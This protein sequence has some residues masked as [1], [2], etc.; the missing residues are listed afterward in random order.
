MSDFEGAVLNHYVDQFGLRDL[1]T[2][3]GQSE[4]NVSFVSLSSI[5]VKCLS[6]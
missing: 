3:Q 6:P 5:I 4:N 1:E 2:V